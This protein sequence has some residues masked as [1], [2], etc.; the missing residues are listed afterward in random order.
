MLMNQLQ[1]DFMT[2]TQLNFSSVHFPNGEP[3]HFSDEA[4]A[5]IANAFYSG[6]SPDDLN[7]LVIETLEVMEEMGVDCDPLNI[8]GNNY[9]N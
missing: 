3:K 8:G 9:G 4:N 5:E 6:M 2:D 1:F 7:Q